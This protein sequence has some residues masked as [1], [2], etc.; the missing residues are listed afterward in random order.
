LIDGPASLDYLELPVLRRYNSLIRGF[1]DRG[2][3][4][5]IRDPH[6]RARVVTLYLDKQQF[7]R[8]LAIPDENSI[9]VYLVRRADR[10]ILWQH[11]GEVTPT[12]LAELRQT[13]GLQ[14]QAAR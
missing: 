9:Y 3:R 10:A 14:R 5:G 6:T 7:R 1:I 2:M 13:L 11:R 4:S 12:T 8:E